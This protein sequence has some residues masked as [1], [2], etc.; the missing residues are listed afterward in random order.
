[1][2]PFRVARKDLK[3]EFFRGGGPGGQHRN[4]RD[5]ACRITHIPTGIS[6]K[7]ESR[8]SQHQNK[9]AAFKQLAA[10]LVPVMRAEIRGAT[11]RQVVSER[12]RTYHEPDQRVVDHRLKGRQWRYGEVIDKDGLADVIE[13]LVKR[14]D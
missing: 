11:V 12:V 7:S 13:A 10:V 2:W 14:V 5:T 3:I 8:R 1:M 6:A 9:I 4:K